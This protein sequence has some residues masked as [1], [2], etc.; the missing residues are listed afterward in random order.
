MKHECNGGRQ[1]LYLSNSLS[2]LFDIVL[3]VR[4]VYW[5]I[6]TVEILG[7]CYDWL[8]AFYQFI[9]NETVAVYFFYLFELMVNDS[10]VNFIGCNATIIPYLLKWKLL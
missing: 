8:F 1:S 9:V 5:T 6:Q 2:L 3:L 7:S 4:P 10:I